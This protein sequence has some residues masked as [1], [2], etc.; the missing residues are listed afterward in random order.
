MEWIKGNIGSDDIENTD[1]EY[2]KPTESNNSIQ[3]QGEFG[4]YSL[5]YTFHKFLLRLHRWLAIF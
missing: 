3:T 1:V 4:F 2:D 5:F